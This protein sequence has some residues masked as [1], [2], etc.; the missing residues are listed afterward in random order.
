MISGCMK[1]LYVASIGLRLLP[2]GACSASLLVVSYIVRRQ[3]PDRPNATALGR[4][5]H[6]RA[7]HFLSRFAGIFPLLSFPSFTLQCLSKA[8]DFFSTACLTFLFLF[9]F[10][11]S[12][13]GTSWAFMLV[14]RE[15]WSFLFHVLFFPFSADENFYYHISQ[16]A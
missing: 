10:P 13:M 12:L 3:N 16:H 7:E 2:F 4:F 11:S 14:S 6:P 5:A 1:L 9:V 15:F 8:E